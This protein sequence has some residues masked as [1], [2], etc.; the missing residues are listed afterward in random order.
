MSHTL[1]E[2]MYIYCKSPDTNKQNTI[3]YFIK[4]HLFERKNVLDMLLKMSGP[5][6][7][8]GSCVKL[9]IDQNGT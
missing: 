7:F 1:I 5:S 6:T 8:P 4:L 9:L 3:F 2:V